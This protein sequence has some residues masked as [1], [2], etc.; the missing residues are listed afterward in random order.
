[1]HAIKLYPPG[2]TPNVLPPTSD[3][4]IEPVLSETYDEVVFTDPAESF[5]RQLMRLSIVPKVE[6]ANQQHMTQFSDQEDFSALIE[7]QRFLQI[8]LSKVK[9]HFQ[10]VT[11]ELQQVEADLHVAQQETKKTK[12]PARKSR[13]TA[14]ISAK[15]A[16]SS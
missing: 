15:K 2:A 11:D 12:A 16:K 6:M 10:R 14:S 9:E 1:M 8:E 3:D 13:P 4:P 5:Y 7:A